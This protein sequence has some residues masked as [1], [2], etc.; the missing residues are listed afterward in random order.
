MEPLRILF[1]AALTVAAAVGLGSWV[2]G[3]ACRELPVRFVCGAALLSLIL[4]VLWTPLGWLATLATLWCAYFFRD[5][6][7][8]TPVR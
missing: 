4:F 2:L 7:R 8:V 1:G 3:S 6:Q 5:P